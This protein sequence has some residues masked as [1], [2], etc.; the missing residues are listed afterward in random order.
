V[1]A[2]PNSTADSNPV[3]K[4][5]GCAAGFWHGAFN[6]FVLIDHILVVQQ[7]N[8]LMQAQKQQEPSEQQILL[9]GFES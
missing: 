7:K 6:H 9:T 3:N 4:E 5:R 8:L 1:K 2:W